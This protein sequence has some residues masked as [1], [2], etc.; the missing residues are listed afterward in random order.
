MLF[1]VLHSA[2]LGSATPSQSL[3]FLLYN[4]FFEP[5]P[6]TTNHNPQTGMSVVFAFAAYCAWDL[7][8]ARLCRKAARGIESKL[9]NGAKSL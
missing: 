9:I 3:F 1:F 4:F 7:L 5:N 2:I 6:Q 8:G